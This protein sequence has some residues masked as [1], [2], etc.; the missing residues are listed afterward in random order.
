MPAEEP[1]SSTK[2]GTRS[3]LWLTISEGIRVLRPQLV[4]VENV[5][6]IRR[7]GLDRWPRSG[8]TR[9]GRAFALQ[10]SAPS[11][12]ATVSFFSVTG[13][14]PASS[15]KLLP[16]PS[17]SDNHGTHPL[18]K[19]RHQI[20]LPDVLGA[21]FPLP[22]KAP[23]VPMTQPSAAGKPSLDVQHHGPRSSAPVANRGSPRHS[24]SG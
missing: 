1:T 8:M 20:T 3:G 6:A 14:E 15:S 16:T 23:G 5:A 22:D 19:T 11:I 24:R 2:Q 12:T 21:L 17:A 18:S 13:Q 9:R 7:R 10:T 4:V